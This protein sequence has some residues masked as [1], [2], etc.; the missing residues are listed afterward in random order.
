MEIQH[1]RHSLGSLASKPSPSPLQSPCL[2]QALNS[3]VPAL[4]VRRL[5]VGT[6]RHGR[7]PIVG[8]VRLRA[9]GRDRH[10]QGGA[11]T[12]VAQRSTLPSRESCRT[13]RRCRT[14][15]IDSV[16][17]NVTYQHTKVPQ[18]TSMCIESCMKRLK[19]LNKPFKYI[20]EPPSPPLCKMLQR[21]PTAAREGRWRSCSRSSYPTRS[22]LLPPFPQK[23]ATVTAVLM[24]KNGAGL[25]TATSCYWDNTTDGAPRPGRSEA[26]PGDGCIGCP[27]S[28]LC[29]IARVTA[30]AAPVR[31]AQGARRS[32]GRTRQ[33]IA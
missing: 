15:A 23:C 10:H 19:D 9:G 26:W 18:W 30:L 14:Q 6:Q 24:Q 17:A 25:H 16:L 33:C 31:R 7:P 13:V 32:D 21:T 28:V 11:S 1:P 12:P 27:H 20:G 8:G 4:P 5:A 29:G 3:P 22:A 2:G